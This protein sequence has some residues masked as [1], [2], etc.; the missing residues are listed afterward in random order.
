MMPTRQQ[1]IQAGRQDLVKMVTRAGGFLDVAAQ[2]GF[3][4]RRRPPG[5]WEDE[6]ALEAEL[7][8][9]VAAHWVVFENPEVSLSRSDDRYWYNQVTHRVTWDEPSM[10]ESVALDSEGSEILVEAEEDRVMPSR[11]SILAAGRYDLHNA[12][13]AAG[14]YVAT[15]EM[16]GRRPAWPPSHRLKAWKMLVVELKEAAEA[17]DLPVRTMPTATMLL[18]QD[19]GDIVRAVAR[20]GGFG[21]VAEKL[22]WRT[23]RRPRNAWQNIHYVLQELRAF[24]GEEEDGGGEEVEVVGIKGVEEG[25]D[26]DGGDGSSNREKKKKEKKRRMPTHE[27]LRRAGRHDL[28]F[29]LQQHGSKVLADMLGWEVPYK[30]NRRE[31]KKGGVCLEQSTAPTR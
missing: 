16:L 29:A 2:L 4:A 1:L 26:D 14:G 21:I 23:F 19:R 3:R 28:R 10:P 24:V 30:S 20:L 31:R 11:S 18:D 17:A 7:A 12:I 25:M 8:Y 22:G 5:Y 9:F 27:E 15:G 6:A 13:T